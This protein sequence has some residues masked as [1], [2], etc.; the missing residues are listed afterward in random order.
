MRGF[1]ICFLAAW[2]L[3]GTFVQQ[4]VDLRDPFA[5]EL[6]EINSGVI[7]AVK[8]IDV[9]IPSTPTITRVKLWLL[10]PY[11]SRVNYS[12][13]KASLNSKS[14]GVVA[15]PMAGA[16][17]K[18]L[19]IDLR[20]H[21]DL[22]LGPGKNVIE[23]TARETESGRTYRCSFVLLR[24]S[25]P[26][27]KSGG[28]GSPE[29]IRV[30]SILAP[31]DPN[32]PIADRQ[33]PKLTLFEPK[34][35]IN[36]DAPGSLV[37]RVAGEASDDRTAFVWVGV[38]GRS[39]VSPPPP[40][41]P[42]KGKKKDL[43]PPPNPATLKTPF[44]QTVTVDP[45]ARALLVEAK[46]SSGNRTIYTIPILRTAAKTAA[47]TA[48]FGGRKFAV[49]V[50]V[51][52]YRYNEAGLG[53]LQFAHADALAVRDWLRSAEGG[54]FKDEDIACLTNENATL[55]AVESVVYRFLT[56]A[57][58]NDLI[59][60]FLAGHGAPDPHNNQK[61][62]FLLHD[63]KVTDLNGTAFPM[64][65]LGEFLEK[66]SKQVRLVAYF[67]T[68]HSAGVKGQPAAQQ[69][70]VKPP[71]KDAAGRM[72]GVGTKAGPS[73]KPD[74]AAASSPPAGS[75][76]N[77]YSAD[78]FK[79]KGWTVLT[80]SGINELSQESALWGNHGVFTWALLEGAKGKADKNGDCKINS[81]ELTQY[82]STTVR[83]ATQN[84]QSPQTL[85][86]SNP[87][88]ALAAVPNCTPRK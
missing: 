22:R 75:A 59:Y 35:A 42:V 79:Q 70:V 48:G 36:A 23:V 57:G 3:P 14:L 13:F 62:Y 27:L 66:Q 28:D 63:S 73:P 20:L 33:A 51:S 21:P 76:F 50:G 52:W 34:G 25:G 24:G 40:A 72:R 19:D 47:P 83:A 65:K 7:D 32:L 12:G 87:E 1:L 2:F 64:A 85:P 86:G 53:N 5:I 31:E 58:E 17:G 38:N 69:V 61:Y 37:V 49:A 68:C 46:D 55:A 67:D 26:V 15:K 54:G 10:E 16:N 43:P 81:A 82:V 8:T 29:D 56:K 78:L 4:T 30:E 71:T 74:D 88:I 18:Y 44:D 9:P 6:P 84:A 60:L 11:A 80:S 41:P 39:I 77:F 45:T